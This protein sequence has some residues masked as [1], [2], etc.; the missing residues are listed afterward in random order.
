MATLQ[1]K[2]ITLTGVF[3]YANT[4]PGAIAL[5]ASGRV[6][7]AGIVT[8]HYPLEQAEEALQAGR[9]DPASVKAMVRPG[10]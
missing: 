4:Y 9:K 2:E 3:R 5:A 1:T 6:N 8:G 7:L 10:A